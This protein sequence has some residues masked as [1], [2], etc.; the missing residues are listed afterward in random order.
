MRLHLASFAAL[1]LFALSALTACPTPK[2]PKGPPPEYEDPPAPSWI[3]GG[4]GEHDGGAPSTGTEAGAPT[5]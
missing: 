3:D 1:A 4:P 2:S 5:S